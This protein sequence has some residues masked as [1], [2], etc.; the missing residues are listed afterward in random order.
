M[1]IKFNAMKCLLVITMLVIASCCNIRADDW[2]NWMGPDRSGVSSESGWSTTWPADGLAEDWAKEIG[3]GFSSIS[4]VD[5]V[6]YSMGHRDGQ[7][8]VWCLDAKTGADVW[9]HSYSAKLNPNLYEGGP[10][11]TPTVSDEFVYT[12]SIDGR[13]LALDRKSGQ[14]RWE[15][16]LKQELGVEMPEWGFDSSPLVLGDQL[17]LQGGRVASFNR[18]TGEKLWQTQ[19]HSAGYGSVCE[20]TRNGKSLLASLDCD[21]LRISDSVD[22]SEIAFQPWKSPY[23]TNSTTPIVVGDL[24]YISTGYNIG[25]GLFRFDGSSLTGVYSNKQMRNH[26]NNSIL[27]EGYLYGFDGNS[28]LGRV[29]T[30]TCMNFETGET[31][32]KE[33][34]LGCGSLMIADGKLVILSETGSLVIAAATS[35]GYQELSRSEILTG[36]CWTAPVLSNGKVYARNASGNL[37]CVQL[38]SLE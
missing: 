24:I 17:I 12:L 11:A 5:G 33:R 2:P 28:N 16:N 21:G 31:M 19:K 4:V 38:P 1:R 22:G 15:K 34:G 29:V 35:T 37:V 23:Q 30:L 32:W 13:L 8:T 7:E 18:H 20:F 3:I 10:G 36:R 14:V 25:C 27:H 9:S 6:L 26:F